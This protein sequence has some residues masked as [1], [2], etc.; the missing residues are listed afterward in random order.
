MLCGRSI[1]AGFRPESPTIRYR[2]AIADPV[3]FSDLE[4]TTAA[5]HDFISFQSIW[6][7]SPPPESHLDPFDERRLPCPSN[8]PALSRS[9]RA[10]PAINLVGAERDRTGGRHEAGLLSFVVEPI[11]AFQFAT[12]LDPPNRR[13]SNHS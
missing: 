10:E 4:F 8:L 7:V 11:L 5:E 6:S 1:R 13:G 2:L 9:F 12:N 3:L